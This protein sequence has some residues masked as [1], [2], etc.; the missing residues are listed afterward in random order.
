MTPERFFIPFKNEGEFCNRKSACLECYI[1]G[2][3]QNSGCR[4]RA[5]QLAGIEL[6][7]QIP[8]HRDIPNIERR[9]HVEDQNSS[10]R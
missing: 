8:V 10:E 3:M 5:K 1:K 4:P 6:I 2:I 7:L 9:D